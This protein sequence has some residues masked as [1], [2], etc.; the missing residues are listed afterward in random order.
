MSLHYYEKRTE[1]RRLKRQSGPEGVHALLRKREVEKRK[2]EEE[3]RRKKRRELI[4][5]RV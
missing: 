2:K 5:A 1:A 4:E 3:E